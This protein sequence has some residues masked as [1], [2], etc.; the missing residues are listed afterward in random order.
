MDGVQHEAVEQGLL[1]GADDGE[2]NFFFQREGRKLVDVGNCNR[3]A[4]GQFG[5]AGIAGRAEQFC[6]ALALG[7]FPNQSVLASAAANNEDSLKIAMQKCLALPDVQRVS[8]GAAGRSLVLERSN[9]DEMVKTFLTT[10]EQ[11]TQRKAKD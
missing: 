6:G 1:V 9:V 7:Q 3:P 4:L 5:N 10:I 11:L 2:V 8:F